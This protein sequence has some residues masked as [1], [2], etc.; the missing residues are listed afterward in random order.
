MLET[1]ELPTLLASIQYLNALDQD[2]PRV[3][4][5]LA[6][7]V[8]RPDELSRDDSRRLLLGQHLVFTMALK[9]DVLAVTGPDGT[10]RELTPP[11]RDAENVDRFTA[12][13]LGFRQRTDDAITSGAEHAD[14]VRHATA[15]GDFLFG[16]LFDEDAIR[17]LERATLSGYP[18]PLI[19]LRSADDVLLSLPW[20]LLHHDG[21]FLVRGGRVDLARST[22]DDV[23]PG[24]LV[25][26]PPDVFKLVVNVSA[27]AGSGL[28]YEGEAYR[29]TRALAE[30]VE[31]T[32]TELGTVE[33]LI[34]TAKRVRPAGLHFSGHGAPGRLQFEDDEGRS[35]DVDVA[36]LAA[37]LKRR[38]PGGLPPF[39]YLASCHGNEPAVPEKGKSASESSAAPCT[40]PGWRRSWA[41]TDRSRTSCR[42]APRRPST[43]PW[44]RARR[45]V[46]PCARRAKPCSVPSGD[47]RVI[48]TRRRPRRRSR[49]PTR[50]P[51]R[52]SCSTTAGRTVLSARPFPRRS[53]V[54]TMRSSSGPFWES[55]SA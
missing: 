29:I 19:T 7:I 30:S 51:G 12:A 2:A 22:P 11:W 55:E 24:A 15:L 46:T 52:S 50:S 6:A 39:F 36:E 31:L 45:R 26:E 14:L 32:P 54:R 10:T 33:D 38:V 20:E 49:C 23:G 37:E 53:G 18:R 34:E 41:T 35:H 4:R 48:A 25:P 17:R 42:R 1:V 8:G 43:A 28:D 16:M 44:P 21:S 47:G 3:A 13:R 40:A 27:P 9:D 5:E